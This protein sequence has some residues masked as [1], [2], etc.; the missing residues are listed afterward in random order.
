M[1]RQ[2]RYRLILAATFVGVGLLGVLLNGVLHPKLPPINF[3]ALIA[4]SQTY[5]RDLEATRQPVPESVSLRELTNHGYLRAA[6]VPGLAGLAVTIALNEGRPH[7]VLVR[8]RFPDGGQ[9]VLLAD[10]SVQPAVPPSG[11]PPAQP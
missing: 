3:P 10:G 7:D 1:K 9:Q 5:R 8:V 2:D 6:D 11:P 4:A